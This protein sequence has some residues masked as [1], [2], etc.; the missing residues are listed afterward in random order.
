MPPYA[1]GLLLMEKRNPNQN[2]VFHKSHITQ[3]HI[4]LR[5]TELTHKNIGGR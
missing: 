5:T 4:T 1:L 3:N 2:E